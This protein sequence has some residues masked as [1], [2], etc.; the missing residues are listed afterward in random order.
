MNFSNRDAF[1]S[2]DRRPFIL[3]SWDDRIVA[4]P[5]VPQSRVLRKLE[6]LPFRPIKM[7]NNYNYHDEIFAQLTTEQK[8]EF[9]NRELERKRALRLGFAL[10]GV[11]DSPEHEAYDEIMSRVQSQGT[12][13]STSR[14]VPVRLLGIDPIRNF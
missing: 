13:A 12:G 8:R 10:T 11:H 5:L 14:T 7:S 6:P 3:A 2:S 4:R 9:A 1:L